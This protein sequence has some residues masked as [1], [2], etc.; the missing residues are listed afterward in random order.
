MSEP[1][2]Y[3]N[4]MLIEASKVCWSVQ[5]NHFPNDTGIF[6]S[7]LV[8]PQPLRAG[9]TPRSCFLSQTVHVLRLCVLLLSFLRRSVSP[10][11]FTLPPEEPPQLLP[12]IFINHRRRHT[13][14]LQPTMMLLWAAAGVPLGAYNIT[15]AFNVALRI[16]PQILTLLSLV[17]WGQCC[18]WGKVSVY[19]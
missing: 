3:Q 10:N 1:A 4:A 9:S 8:C 16:Q 7:S 2:V 19:S 5:V 13:V 12:Q 15:E 11:P 14:G 17:T 18:Y 6:S